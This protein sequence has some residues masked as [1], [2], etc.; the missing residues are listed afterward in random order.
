MGCV[1]AASPDFRGDG[2]RTSAGWGKAGLG[3]DH[4]F[5]GHALNALDA[6]GRVSVPASFRATVAQ[7]LGA[8]GVASDGKGGGQLM[9][10]PHPKGDRLRAYDAV[11]IAQLTEELKESVADLP[12][13]ERREA[14]AELRREEIGNMVPVPFDGAGRMVLPPVL[15][16]VCGFSDLA[17]FMGVDDHIEI[18][19]PERAEAA[20]ANKPMMLTVLRSYLKARDQ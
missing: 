15:R 16:E 3:I 9:I 6:K 20:F 2:S 8:Q 18:W 1:A 5:A 11:G 17:Y 7:R 14:L 12:A 4:P 13:A 19:A 10:A